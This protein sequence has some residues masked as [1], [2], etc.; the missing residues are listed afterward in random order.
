MEAVTHASYQNE[1]QLSHNY[2]R[3]E[4]LGDALLDLVISRYLWEHYPHANP[5]QLTILRSYLNRHQTLQLVAQA[6][7]LS[8]LILIGQGESNKKSVEP[9]LL[10]DL[11]ESVLGA[12]YLDAGLRTAQRFIRQTLFSYLTTNH[13]LCASVQ[14]T[15]VNFQQ[16]TEFN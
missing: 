5:G 3:L 1:R 2:Q 8:R 6:I 9:R 10:G 4:F 13:L 11:F 12:I 16:H 14:T 7:D 15:I